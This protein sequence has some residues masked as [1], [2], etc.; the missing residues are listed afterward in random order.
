M[1]KLNK[2]TESVDETVAYS[3]AA[4]ETKQT[5]ADVMGD[6]PQPTLR[7]IADIFE[8]PQQRIYSVAKQPVAGQVYDARVYNWGAISR[9]IE[10]RI[11]KE[12]DKFQ[13]F[14]DVYAA[15]IA[16]DEELASMD[17][18]RG[19]RTGSGS[20]K[21]MIDIGDGKQMPV[22]RKELNI[23]DTVYLKR[24]DVAFEVVYLTATH[25]V[26]KVAGKPTLNCLSNWTFNQ[27]YTDKAP[28][29]ATATET[30]GED[31]LGD[32]ED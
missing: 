8:V 9:F 28:E 7:A 17:H 5:F 1:A 26:L 14:E 20:S 25:V 18:R 6:R 23:G 11:G 13:T 2:K 3:D 10:K 21:V 30:T 32:I 15:A 4:V 19:P 22:R 31:D 16:R 27:Q 24:Y 12:G 29:G